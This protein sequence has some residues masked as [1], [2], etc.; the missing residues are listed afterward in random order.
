MPSTFMMAAS[1]SGRSLVANRIMPSITTTQTMVA[2]AAPRPAYTRCMSSNISRTR[3]TSE[4]SRSA[5]ARLIT[6]EPKPADSSCDR[7]WR[8]GAADTRA[9]RMKRRSADSAAQLPHHSRCALTAI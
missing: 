4:T 7:M 1:E 6:A 3:A 5:L 2:A 9:L 8:P